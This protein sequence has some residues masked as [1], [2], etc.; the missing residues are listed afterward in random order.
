MKTLADAWDWYRATRQNLFRMQRLGS[1][2]WNEDFLKDPSFWKDE[3]FKML[4][5]SDIIQETT[6]GL[7]PIDDLAIIVLFSVFEST[8]RDY[9]VALIKPEA[10]RLIDP[11]LRQVAEEAIRGVEEGSFYRR[12][13]EPL[14]LQN[15]ISPDLITQI[16]QIRDYRNWAAHGRRNKPVNYV[17]PREAFDRLKQFLS[18]LGIPVQTEHLES[19]LVANENTQER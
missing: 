14:K 8:V 13:L 4:D 3:N 5:A 10:D 9:L 19:E 16:D 11:I 2:Y 7:E 17:T 12:I 15:R 1:S 6:I 18:E